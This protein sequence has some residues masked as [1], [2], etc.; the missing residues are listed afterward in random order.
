MWVILR[1][2]LFPFDYLIRGW[3]MGFQMGWLKKWKYWHKR[4]Y[5]EW[6]KEWQKDLIKC[7]G[8]TIL[9]RVQKKHEKSGA[10]KKIEEYCRKRNIS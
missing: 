8:H 1:I 9:S 6:Y 10:L 4:W 2:A 3:T 5:L 7:V